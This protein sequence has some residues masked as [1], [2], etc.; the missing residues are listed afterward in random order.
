MKNAPNTLIES[1]YERIRDDII[2]GV[3]APDTKLRIEQLRAQYGI[4]ASPL[5][6]AL[7][8]LSGEGL[9][10]VVGQRGFKV[11]SISL[12]DFHTITCL[13]IKLEFEALRQSIEKGNDIW[14]ANMIAAFHRLSKAKHQK[15]EI[16]NWE[17]RHDAF[18]Q[19]LFAGCQPGWLLRFCVTLYE[20][21]KRYRLI[22]M[23]PHDIVRDSNQEREQIMNAALKKDADTA[24]QKNEAYIQHIAE[25]TRMKLAELQIKPVN[26]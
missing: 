5:R 4:S 2:Y 8:R 13:R 9:V 17:K 20:Q 26:D 3:L 7:N 25:H 21:D 16:N 15:Y 24:C 12:D 22:S 11:S 14:E 6:E 23:L 18:H 1:I 10:N 19:S